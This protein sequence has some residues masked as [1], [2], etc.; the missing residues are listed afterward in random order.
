VCDRK[1]MLYV[2]YQ[3]Y[4][5]EIAMKD[6]LILQN[7][8]VLDGKTDEAEDTKRDFKVLH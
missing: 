5:S 7:K 8:Q 4:A 1:F 2:K 6:Q 3:D